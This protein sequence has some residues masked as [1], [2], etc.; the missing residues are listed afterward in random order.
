VSLLSPEPVCNV[1]AT[2]QSRKLFRVA[3]AILLCL[4]LGAARATAQ[5]AE[6][7]DARDEKNEK[8][9]G[10]R[11]A[12]IVAF[13]GGAATALAAHEAF[14]VGFGANPRLARVDSRWA[15]WVS[16]AAKIGLVVLVLR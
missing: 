15:P 10:P 11:A 4:A 3:G 9:A 12:S 14:D 5:V 16:R 1:G 13:L 2:R 8:T 6:G 7:T